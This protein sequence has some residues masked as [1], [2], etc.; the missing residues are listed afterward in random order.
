MQ[1]ILSQRKLYHGPTLDL[2]LKT[3]PLTCSVDLTSSPMGNSDHAILPTYKK[4][5]YHLQKL[6]YIINKLT[7][8]KWIFLQCLPME[9]FSNNVSEVCDEINEEYN[10]LSGFRIPG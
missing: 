8:K 6:Y 1:K 7:G 5:N 2:F 9:C 3:D 10:V 4:M